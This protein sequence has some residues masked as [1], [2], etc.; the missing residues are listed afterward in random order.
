[1]KFC[2]VLSSLAHNLQWYYDLRPTLHVL[3]RF[4]VQLERS[5]EDGQRHYSIDAG[6]L[7]P[8]AVS[9]RGLGLIKQRG[10][11]WSSAVRVRYGV[12]GKWLLNNNS[13][14]FQDKN[15]T[16]FSIAC[17][18]PEDLEKMQE[19]HMTQNLHSESVSI[20]TYRVTAAHELHCSQFINL[21]HK[22][23]FIVS[24]T[25]MYSLVS[26]PF[27]TIFEKSLHLKTI[28]MSYGVTIKINK[29]SKCQK[30]LL[31]HLFSKYV[32]F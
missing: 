26:W 2:S 27:L 19:C 23:I 1:M 20:Q 11:E 32:L 18:F 22:V 12:Q 31:L 28:K 25:Q 21:N 5:L 17:I 8:S 7:L 30:N 13:A 24:I 29:C 6:F 4:T 14:T 16:N 10:P 3:P 15:T 9:V